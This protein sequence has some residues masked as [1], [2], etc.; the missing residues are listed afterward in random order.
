MSTEE[1]KLE[2][3]RSCEEILNTGNLSG[4]DER[5]STSE[6]EARERQIFG[7]A[8]A[9]ATEPSKLGQ[10][11]QLL[12]HLQGQRGLAEDFSTWALGQIDARVLSM[13]LAYAHDAEVLVQLL[14]F[15]S[16]TWD[17]LIQAVEDLYQQEQIS[18]R[19]YVKVKLMLRAHEAPPHESGTGVDLLSPGTLLINEAQQQQADESHRTAS[20]GL[21]QALLEMLAT[22]S[23]PIIVK[24]ETDENGQPFYIWHI[25]E[26]TSWQP[27]GLYVGTNRQ[28]LDALK[29]AF[30][31]L[32]KHVGQQP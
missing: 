4:S 18:Q 27:F 13:A 7:L 28:L 25:G 19:V 14:S 6:D 3:R 23:I 9:I 22:V 10:L 11:R 15:K 8:L 26:S 1:N 5:G 30:E 16:G 20:A 24:V 31:K 17:S 29:L 2:G 21:E 12:L 32:I